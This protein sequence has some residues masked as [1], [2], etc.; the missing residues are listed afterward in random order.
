MKGKYSLTHNFF[1]PNL[2]GGTYFS[3]A[4]WRPNKKFGTVAFYIVVIPPTKVACKIIECAT[5]T[6]SSLF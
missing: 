4:I 2:I 6:I 3:K 5:P 1:Y